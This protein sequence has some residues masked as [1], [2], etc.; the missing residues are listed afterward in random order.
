[1][2]AVAVHT[3]TQLEQGWSLAAHG[4]QQPNGH[5]RAAG[6]G[7]GMEED[8]SSGE[9]ET[10]DEAHEAHAD[11]A[12]PAQEQQDMELGTS[13]GA[14]AGTAPL[15]AAAAAATSSLGGVAVLTPG[16]V[17]PALSPLAWRSWPLQA[18]QAD[19]GPLDATYLQLFLL[20]H[21]CPVGGCLGLLAPQAAGA[22][23]LQCNVC[24]ALRSEADFLAE[25]DS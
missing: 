3:H 15:A 7:D 13:P 24:G 9:W 14:G 1:M 22:K 4:Q 2:S 10:D 8:G 21:V 19:P 11:A 5:H 6:G 20:K 12:G 17:P 18:E 16:G 23:T 25:L